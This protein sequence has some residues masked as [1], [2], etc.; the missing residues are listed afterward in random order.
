MFEEFLDNKDSWINKKEFSDR[1]VFSSRLRLARNLTDFPFPS[2]LNDSAAKLLISKFNHVKSFFKN[3]ENFIFVNISDL[4]SQDK[5]FLL[6]RHLVSQHFLCLE[7]GGLIFSSDEKI[8]IMINEEDHLR[9]QVIEAGFDLK[10]G[11]EKLNQIDDS[12]A[13][14]FSYAFMPDLGYLTSCPTNAGT[15]L[16]A[17]CM[18]H[19]PG[20]IFT[21]KIEKVLQF[22]TKISF[23]IRGFFG[24]GSRSLG[25]FF[26]ISNQIS[27]G[28]NEE[29]IIDNL[30]RV[31]S[32]V[33]QHEL[34]AR[35]L[36]LKKFKT[37]LE[38]TVWR[39]LG[40]MRNSRLINC[41]ET[42]KHL[43]ALSLGI[44][45]GIIREVKKEVVKSLFI[46]TQPVHIQKIEGRILNQ[47]E[48]DFLRAK[49]L[50][51]KLS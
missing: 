23:T 36:L 8:S 25:D 51:E 47:K 42:L 26:Q 17:S 4:D 16:R 44:D 3:G 35:Q 9:L 29:E 37:N 13:R 33:S 49:L 27:L 43:S 50:R 11:W 45:L 14:K 46:T 22:L 31:V 6:E 39:A 5:E 34:D 12:F 20:L 1:V 15:A 32:Q 7:K 18:L 2:R 30:T 38:D 28:V 24:E 40:V 19:L 10:K 21:K 41:K 48:R